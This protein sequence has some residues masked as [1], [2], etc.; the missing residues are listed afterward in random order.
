M[1]K[2][3]LQP[4]FVTGLVEGEGCFSVSFTLR[5]KLNLGIEAR[6]SF[7]LSLNERDLDLLKQVHE[8][9][10]CGAIR[11]SKSDRTYKYEVRSVSDL[12]KEVNPHFRKHPLQG[13]KA[14]DWT[15]F[16]KL[17]E[18]IHANLHLS[19]KHLPTI[20]EAAY[21]MNPSGKRRHDKRTLLKMLDE[22]KV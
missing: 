12:V 1:E 4:W 14:K 2:R 20:I 22:T 10:G 19:S 8:F 9:F 3:R 5:K 16:S 6:P 21:Q 15:L 18:Q 13:Q 17:C 11:Y 7:S